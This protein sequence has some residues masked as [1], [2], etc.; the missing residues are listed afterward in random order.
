V[1]GHEATLVQPPKKA[2]GCRIFSSKAIVP[3][4]AEIT[5]RQRP[6]Q[7]SAG[8]PREAKAALAKDLA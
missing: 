3:F 5:S 6:Y 7:M 2:L 1:I 4:A 8:A